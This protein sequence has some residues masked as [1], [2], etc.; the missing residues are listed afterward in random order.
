MRTQKH[1]G[2]CGQRLDIEYE[3]DV[4]VSLDCPKCKAHMIWTFDKN[5]DFDEIVRYKDGD[6]IIEETTRVE[7]P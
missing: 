4:S 7:M 6:E 3:V 1:C 2:R 5:G